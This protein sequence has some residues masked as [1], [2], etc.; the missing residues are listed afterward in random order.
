M[1]TYAELKKKLRPN[2]IRTLYLLLGPEEFLAR[3]L[4][5]RIVDLALDGGMKEFNFAELDPVIVEPGLLR[6]ELNAYPLGCARRVV[7]IRNVSSLNVTVQDALAEMIGDLPA[8]LTLILTA[9]RLDRRKSLYKAISSVGEV[10]ELN[11]LRATEAKA[12]IRELLEEHGKR[13]S[14]KV[15]E[16]IFEL[17]GTDLSDISNEIRNLVDYMSGRDTVT[18]EDVSALV[19]SRRKEPIY[20][21]TESVADRNLVDA[22][23][24]LQRLLAEGEHELRILWHLDFMVKRLLRAKCLQEEGVSDDAVIKAL[25]IKPFLKSRFLQQVRSFSL[26]ELRRM[27]HAIVEWD[28]KFKSTSRWHPDID[29]ELLVRELCVTPKR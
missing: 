7:V 27:Y 25:Q 4:I 3:R 12:W 19:A 23:S 14:G 22:W 11:T 18:E 2:T 15:V 13:V 9:D 16:S 21:L 5:A 24:S 20:S 8:F 6:E 26:E 28:I 1:T 10:V 29:L 17:T